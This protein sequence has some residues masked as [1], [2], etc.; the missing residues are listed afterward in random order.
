M[1]TEDTAVKFE[2]STDAGC[3]GGGRC[4][5]SV[6]GSDAGTVE[7]REE[8]FPDDTTGHPTVKK[9]GLMTWKTC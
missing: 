2:N 3:Y 9:R 7:D 1:E 6:K 8:F 5:S 4:G